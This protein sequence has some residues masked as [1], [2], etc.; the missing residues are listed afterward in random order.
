LLRRLPR[1]RYR[2][3]AAFAPSRGRLIATLA[4]ELG[5]ARFDCDLSDSLSREV[6]FTGLYEPPVTR[7]FQRHVPRGGTVV[8]AGANWGYFSLIAAALSGADGRVIA[9]EPDPRQFEALSHNL[10]LNGFTHVQPL[11]AAAAAVAGQLTLAGYD[12][13]AVN[14]GVSRV[15][16]SPDGEESSRRF[17]VQALTIDAVT[18]AF[19]AVDLVKIDVEGAEDLVLQGMREGLASRRYRAILLELHP[20]LLRARGVDPESCVQLLLDYGYRGW[21]IDASPAAYRRAIDPALDVE[22]LLRPLMEWRAAAWPHLLW[23]C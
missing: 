16:G 18:A 13:D 12:D 3:L 17:T 23:L 20:G 1:G 15:I 8:D 2:L 21:T 22:T 19:A 7:V 11:P 10:S 14:R 4:D 9:L 6:C 5:A